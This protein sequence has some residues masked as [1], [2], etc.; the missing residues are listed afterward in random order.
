LGCGSGE[1]ATRRIAEC[2]RVIGVDASAVQLGLARQA[3][4]SALLVQADMTRLAVKPGS[5]DAV[6]SF[7]ALGH[8]PSEGHAP[9]FAAIAGWL[10]PGGV[11]VTSAPVGAGD[12]VDPSWLGTAMFFGGIGVEA[13]RQAVAAAGLRLEMLEALDEDEGDGNIVR[14]NWLIASKPSAQ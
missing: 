6:A 14:F 12:D 8:V 9:L 4:P 5:V 1:P 2:H 7:Y 11:L 3:A 10:R 13:T